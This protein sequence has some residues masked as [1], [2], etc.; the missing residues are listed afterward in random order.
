M[1]RS[2]LSVGGVRRPFAST[3][4]APKPQPTFT[5]QDV[6][7]TETKLDTPYK[8]LTGEYVKTVNV[9]GQEVLQVDPKA[10]TLLANQ[11]RHTK[12]NIRTPWGHCAR[13]TENEVIHA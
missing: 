10:L 13:Q 3:P 4:S 9:E 12:Q 6:F 1:V 8:K 11:V 5:Y 7:Q 2:S